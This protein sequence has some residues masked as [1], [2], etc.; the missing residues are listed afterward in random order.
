MQGVRWHTCTATAPSKALSAKP[1]HNCA[2]RSVDEAMREWKHGSRDKERA[3]KRDRGGV[4]GDHDVWCGY[5]HA[6]D[7]VMRDA[8]VSMVRHACAGLAS[9]AT[10]PRQAH[11]S[12]ACELQT[13]AH[14]VKLP[15][16]KSAPACRLRVLARLGSPRENQMASAEHQATTHLTESQGTR[17]QMCAQAE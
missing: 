12:L 16:I 7:S 11:C 13:T 17:G 8:G 14:L 6:C 5:G 1:K 15:H 4:R 10:C 2:L 9:L 3:L